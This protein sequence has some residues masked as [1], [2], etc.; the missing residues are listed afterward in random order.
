MEIT[1]LEELTETMS[2]VKRTR[3]CSANAAQNNTCEE[4]FPP[5]HFKPITNEPE[6]S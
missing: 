3:E 4:S 5:A 2:N 6:K 1:L